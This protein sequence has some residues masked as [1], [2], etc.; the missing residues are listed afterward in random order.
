MHVHIGAMEVAA[1][2]LMLII[3]GFLFRT[4]QTKFPDSPVAKGLMYVY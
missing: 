3:V 1:F 4:I 2:A